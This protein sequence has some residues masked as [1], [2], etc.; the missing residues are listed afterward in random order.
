MLVF[1]VRHASSVASEEGRWQ[2]PDSPLS[3]LG[4]KQSQALSNRSRF[5]K[6]DIVLASKWA[7]AKETGGIV[8]EALSKPLELFE[9][10]HEREQNPKIYGAKWSGKIHKKYYKDAFSNLGNLD[11][12]FENL[13]ESYRDVAKRA[14]K[15]KR[16][17]VRKHKGQNLIV[18]S[19]DI[20]IRCFLAV[21]ILGEKYSDESF[22]KIFRSIRLSSTGIS[23]LEY[24]EKRKTWKV[25]YLND[26]SHLKM[27]K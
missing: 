26:F 18:I 16:H 10:I 13:G 22:Y 5:N 4:K 8:A 11:Y 21:C 23:L 7:R 20:F 17:L 9:G 19:H 14:T 6:V 12:K 15:F 1:L 27:V 25:W 24:D 3:D 2:L